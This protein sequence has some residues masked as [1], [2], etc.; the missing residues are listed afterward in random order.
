VDEKNWCI[1]I[2]IVVSDYEGVVLAAPNTTKNFMVVLVVAEALV[3]FHVVEL[4][5]EMGFVDIILEG[6][7]LQIVNV[8]K[9]IGNN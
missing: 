2:G 9:K 8:V 3:A 7:A 6:D 5:S 4:C 1:G